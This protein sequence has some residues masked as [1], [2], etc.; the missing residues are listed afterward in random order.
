MVRVAYVVVLVLAVNL[1]R[2]QAAPSLLRKELPVW[3]SAS[4]LDLGSRFPGCW[5][6]TRGRGMGKVVH[7]CAT[8]LELSGLLCYPPC[9]DDFNGVGPVC[10][11]TCSASE[12]DGG[13]FCYEKEGKSKVHAKKSYGRG[14]GEP[15]QCSKEE[16][17]DD[18]F[19]GLCYP[20]CPCK[21]MAGVGPVCW[22]KCGGK[23][24]VDGG[25]L[26]CKSA[27]ECESEIF[28]LTEKL[29]VALARAV[30]DRKSA[31][32]EMQDIK[33]L[34][35]DALGFVLPLCHEIPNI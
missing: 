7:E 29:P 17:Q 19:F 12:V 11:E 15:L 13:V 26:C 8:G 33:D 4:A 14:V 5:K 23:Y 32:K 28:N 22:S 27:K 3:A 34:I 35:E 21:D 24:P 20:E 2:C 10:W 16:Q 6:D 31:A 9:K 25:A 18:V 30:L 1:Q